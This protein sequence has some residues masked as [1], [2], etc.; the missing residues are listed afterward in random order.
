MDAIGNS[1]YASSGAEAADTK[2]LCSIPAACLRAF[3]KDF[4]SSALH[5][6]H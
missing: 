6:Q 1:C 5:A 2:W 3:R 4:V